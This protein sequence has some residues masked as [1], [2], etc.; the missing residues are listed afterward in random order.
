MPRGNRPLFLRSEPLAPRVARGL[1]LAA[2]L[3]LLAW[4]A[5]QLWPG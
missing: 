5:S 4:G 2:A 1:L 3:L